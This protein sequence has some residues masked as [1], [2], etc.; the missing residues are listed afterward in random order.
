[1]LTAAHNWDTT[2]V[3]GLSF[4]IGGVSYPAQPAAWLQNPGW[5]SSPSVSL[6]QGWDMALFRLASPV[7]GVVPAT[8]YG[9]TSELGASVTFLGAGLA[10]TAATGPR[11][12]STPNFYA[13]T[14]VIDRVLSM[15]GA[16]GSGGLLAWDFDDGSTLRNTL[17]G[18]AVANETG[19]FSTVTGAM[20]LAQSSS[21][22]PTSFEATSAA[23]DSGAPV[24]AD[25]GTGPELI[26]LVSWGVNPSAPANLY[27]SGYGDI[28]Y[29]TRISAQRDWIYATIPEPAWSALAF[30]AG[31]LILAMLRRRRS[32]SSADFQPASAERKI[33]AVSPTGNFAP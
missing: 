29:L 20:V 22:S 6:N 12:N 19:T 21:V 18:V 3:T 5:V 31:M 23:G 17:T 30:G 8:L 24:F 32:H 10:G 13:G 27:G 7:V 1:M 16:A 2:A 33:D 25:F 15:D 28:T 14:N 9:G 4:H 11:S 26:G